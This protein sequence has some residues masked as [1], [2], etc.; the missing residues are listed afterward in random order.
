MYGHPE[1]THQQLILHLENSDSTRSQCCW[2][3]DFKTARS[4][5]DLIQNGFDLL[6]R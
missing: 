2:Q 3:H 4:I 6:E 1:L 5:I